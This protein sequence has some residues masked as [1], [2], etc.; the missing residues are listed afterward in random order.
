[1]ETL[2]LARQA[3]EGDIATYVNGVKKVSLNWV[4]GHIKY[5]RRRGLTQQDLRVITNRIKSDPVYRPL[6]TPEKLKRLKEVKK[7]LGI[8]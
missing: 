1:M 6:Q 2:E 3:A 7:A 8:E 5:Q 4:V